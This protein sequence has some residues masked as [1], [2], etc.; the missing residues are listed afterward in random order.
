MT[1]LTVGLQLSS[2]WAELLFRSPWLF[3]L[4]I[5]PAVLALYFLKLKRKPLEV[6]STYLWHK[7]IE[8]LHVNSLW[9]KLRQ[10]LLL[11]LQLLILLFALLALFRPSWLGNQLAGERHIF[12]IDTS[13]SMASQDADSG[14]S[15]LQEAKQLV[16]G[17]L[18]KMPQGAVGMLI[19]FSD[20]ARVEQNFTGNRTELFRP[21]QD[22][23]RMKQTTHTTGLLEAVTL[24]GSLANPTSSAFD[25]TDDRASEAL[26]ARLYI[27][28]DGRVEWPKFSL[29]KLEP[30]FIPLG[31]RDAKNVGIVIFSTRPHEKIAGRL[32]AYARLQ[33]FGLEEMSVVANLYQNEN[34]LDAKQVKLP[35]AKPYQPE[36]PEGQP[37]AP[38]KPEDADAPPDNQIGL[39]FDLADFESG[40]L[41][42]K[43]DVQDDFALDNRAWAAVNP[44]RPGRVLLVTPGNDPL[45]RAL[46][47]TAARELALVEVRAPADLTTEAY[48]KAAQSG[49]YDLILYDRCAPAELPQANTFFIGSL[50]PPPKTEGPSNATPDPKAPKQPWWSS[51]G[52]AQVPAI[53]D[54]DRAHPLM[55]LLDL[56]D[57]LVLASQGELKGP[58]GMHVLLDSTGGPLLAIAP[59]EGFED[60]VL[61]FELISGQNGWGTNWPSRLSFPTFAFNILKYLGSGE[62]ALEGSN[63]QPGKTVSLRGPTNNKQLVVVKPNGEKI[64]VLRNARG[65]FEVTDTDLLGPYEV[66]WGPNQVQRFTVNLFDPRESDIKRARYLFIGHSDAI[67]EVNSTA[68]Q[69]TA[70]QEAWR[71][72]LLLAL[73]VLVIEWYIYNRRV[74]L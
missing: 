44:R 36:P 46:T 55:D 62:D 38:P 58:R 26:P 11:F 64:N 33:N 60:T 3:L 27:F 74:Y 63:V 66:Q 45:H 34:L 49:D 15:R 39:T 67:R 22:P 41:D 13:A 53:I 18:E 14:R 73:A 23:Q 21:L 40:V 61:G 37:E 4:P 2:G 47:T 68:V 42:L 72:L 25:E 70:R 32:Q 35:P 48:K 16:Q 1:F 50:P 57:V 19:S 8:D 9:Q 52:T 6:P 29:G 54:I 59:R 28:S 30:E 65:T 7:S 71:P 56:G 10:S 12:L 5:P 43:L 17:Y 24:A 69:E 31:K 51:N 20:G